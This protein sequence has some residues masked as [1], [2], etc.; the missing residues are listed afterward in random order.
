MSRAR[1]GVS[2]DTRQDNPTQP[3]G[4]CTTNPKHG[5]PPCKDD[6]VERLNKHGEKCCYKKS[7]SDPKDVP[8]ENPVEDNTR[9]D[10]PEKKA[11]T[12]NS[13]KNVFGTNPEI[14]SSSEPNTVPPEKPIDDTLTDSPEH[15]AAAP[16]PEKSGPEINRS[17]ELSSDDSEDIPNPLL[18]DRKTYNDKTELDKFEFFK[19][20][21]EDFEKGTQKERE[22]IENELSK[23]KHQLPSSRLDQHE[24]F[25]NAYTGNLSNE[26]QDFFR[27]TPNQK[28]LRTFLTPKSENRGILLFHEVGVGKTCSSILLAE[29]FDAYM[30]NKVMI[31]GPPSLESNYKLELFNK[32]K[33]DFKNKTYD[34]CSGMQFIKDF[35]WTSMTKDEVELR[36]NKLID[37]KYEFFGFQKLMNEIDKLVST[38][39]NSNDEEYQIMKRMS[40]SK[41]KTL[42]NRKLIE[43]F[44]NRIIII[45]EVQ[46]LR[47]DQENSK[48]LPIFLERICKLASNVRLILLSATP[49]FDKVSEISTLIDL[50]SSVDKHYVT[51]PSKI[52]F[53]N[54]MELTDSSESKLKLFARNYVSFMSGRDNVNFPIQY[55][56]ENTPNP[57]VTPKRDWKDENDIQPLKSDFFKFHTVH[58]EDHQKN[59]YLEASLNNEHTILTHLSNIAY[60]SKKGTLE[61]S[62]HE[63]G[64]WE[65]FVKGNNKN[66][67]SVSYKEKEPNKFFLD[68]PNI[69]NYSSKMKSVIESVEECNGQIIIY[70]QLI[71]SGIIPIAIALEHIGFSKFK[72]GGS[73]GNILLSKGNL[74]KSKNESLKKYV[75]LS[76]Y[77]NISP[78]NDDDL[79]RFNKGEVRI[80][81][82][83]DV[84][85][86]GV[87]F[88]NVRELHVLDPWHNMNKI[89]QIIGRGVRF[90]SH[91]TLDEFKRNVGV[92]LHLSQCPG[93]DCESI[94][95]RKYRLSLEKHNQIVKVENVLK[96]NA[97]DC[98]LNRLRNT[99]IDKEIKITDSKDKHMVII[100]KGHNFECMQPD[101]KPPENFK[102]IRKT[103]LL[104]DI[105]DLAKSIRKHVEKKRLYTFTTTMME[106][107][108]KNPL[109]EY[110]LS[111]FVSKSNTKTILDGVPGYFFLLNK[112]YIFQ[113][114]EID[115]RKITTNERKSKKVKF[116]EHFVLDDDSTNFKSVKTNLKV[117]FKTFSEEL[118]EMLKKCYNNHDV[119]EGV[120]LDMY[121][122]SLEKADY[123]FLINKLVK[124]ENVY[125][126]APEQSKWN[127]SLKRG[128]FLLCNKTKTKTNMYYY[129]YFE[130]KFIR[131]DKQTELSDDIIREL[132]T[133]LRVT[134][135]NMED[136]TLIAF[137]DLK[138][139]VLPVVKIKNLNVKNSSGSICAQTSSFTIS[140][141][142]EL[143]S[144]LKPFTAMKRNLNKKEL[145][146]IYEYLLRVE[147][148]Y[149]RYPHYKFSYS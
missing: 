42:Q 31:I 110:S 127:D 24:Y 101:V 94:D 2:S 149:Q 29:N 21:V 45:D 9:K 143:S 88:R 50:L 8:Q 85:A 53:D 128:G 78:N 32:E 61:Y 37:A 22:N 108:F 43:K 129:N 144:T 131:K 14:N 102:S 111:Y 27:Y 39:S 117:T 70:S 147:N 47:T 3:K 141:L 105:I 115:D 63:N 113:P 145:C 92:Y 100:Q 5:Q 83:S 60:P 19:K 76:G 95:Y 34:S 91:K 48:Q 97:L 121:I 137:S 12:P 17:H 116:I 132:Y 18:Q 30:K 49:M 142:K 136:D 23:Y 66:Y 15:K 118:E 44:S 52:E 77:K 90:K 81:I 82:I 134:A 80:A 106:K 93:T 38:V 87:S 10:S 11:E 56:V 98:Q 84:A 133:S 57:F 146:K 72:Q 89:K 68:K 54:N 112:Q 35:D 140:I 139:S 59:K 74:S 46:H 13:E 41:V 69:G 73:S 58:M 33:L 65:N 25:L 124:D 125:E 135:K 20:H 64:F 122:D 75:I 55:F 109:L 86:E 114:E 62:T 123:D 148:K 1:G 96:E 26:N 99:T 104:L 28:F 7:K 6:R 130:D 40:P 51:I 103:M 107:E 4:V 16:N 79:A 138:D 36:V 71:W 126:G 120:I 67:L 119:N